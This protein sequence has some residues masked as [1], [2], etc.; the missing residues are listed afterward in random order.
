MLCQ[1]T[2]VINSCEDT[3]AKVVPSQSG[4][5]QLPNVARTG[6]FVHVIARACS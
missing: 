4:T 2:D 5:S 3:Y 1:A 6:Q